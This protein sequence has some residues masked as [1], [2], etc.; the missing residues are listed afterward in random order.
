MPWGSRRY[1]RMP[2]SHL[3][4]LTGLLFVQLVILLL[5]GPRRYGPNAP[6]H[7]SLTHYTE[8]LDSH[9][10]ALVRGDI[11]H[12]KGLNQQE[13]RRC[14]CVHTYVSAV[15]KAARWCKSFAL[16]LGMAWQVLVC[17]G[18]FGSR[19]ARRYTCR[20]VPMQHEASTTSSTRAKGQQHPRP[21]RARLQE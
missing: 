6:P 4:D 3:Q 12:D 13:V 15:E 16:L 8:L 19:S 18:A 20:V 14:A 7:L 17:T 5:P 10:L 11:I 21:E 9:G 2:S 1:F